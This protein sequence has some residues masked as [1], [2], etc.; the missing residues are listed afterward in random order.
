[1]I[2]YKNGFKHGYCRFSIKTIRYSDYW[3]IQTDIPLIIAN[4]YTYVIVPIAQHANLKGDA[5]PSTACAR[6]YS[7]NI[8][9]T[10]SQLSDS[11][12]VNHTAITLNCFFQHSI[13]STLT[14]QTIKHVFLRIGYRQIK[15]TSRAILKHCTIFKSHTITLQ[16]KV[17]RSIQYLNPERVT[18]DTATCRFIDCHNLQENLL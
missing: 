10:P 6:I 14:I 2:S 13:H 4:A 15:S 1:M 5:H 8:I 12:K 9:T 11:T 18:A 7:L 16:F 3:Q 17:A